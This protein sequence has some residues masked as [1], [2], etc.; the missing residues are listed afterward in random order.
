M[1]EA[2]GLVSSTYL[3]DRE[4]RLLNSDPPPIFFSLAVYNGGL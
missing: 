4:G 1:E 2:P 3:N